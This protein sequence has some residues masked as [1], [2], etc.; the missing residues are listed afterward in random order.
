M[1]TDKDEKAKITPS[2]EDY[3]EKLYFLQLESG[4]VRVTDLAN[5][6]NIKKPSVNKAVNT[7][8]EIGY[9]NHETYGLL[10]LTQEGRNVAEAVARRHAVLKRFLKDVIGVPEKTSEDDACRMEHAISSETLDR[11]EVFARAHL[12]IE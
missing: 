8:K 4:A 1:R 12:K 2:L 9:V 7:L 10:S 5:V 3:L 6:L 11:I